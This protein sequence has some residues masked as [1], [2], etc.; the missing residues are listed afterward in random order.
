MV[1]NNG[2]V[3]CIFNLVKTLAWVIKIK[4]IYKIEVDKKNIILQGSA[5]VGKSYAAKRLAYSIIGEKDNE[6]VKMIQFH[7]R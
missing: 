5:G 4:K 7:L 6:Q 3:R 2:L 1:E